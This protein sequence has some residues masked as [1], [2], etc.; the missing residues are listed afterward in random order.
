MNKF[1]CGCMVYCLR[2]ALT[3]VKQSN[4]LAYVHNLLLKM[5]IRC[6]DKTMHASEDINYVWWMYRKHT[7]EEYISSSIL[8]WH[9]L[10]PLRTWPNTLHDSRYWLNYHVPCLI[11]RRLHDHLNRLCTCAPSDWNIIFDISAHNI[12]IILH[13]YIYKLYII[14]YVLDHESLFGLYLT[15]NA[16]DVQIIFLLQSL[17]HCINSNECV[18]SARTSTVQNMYISTN[19]NRKRIITFVYTSTCTYTPE[20]MQ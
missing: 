13:A 11:Y 9:I 10:G 5:F 2:V 7:I 1:D 12:N 17:H 18:S 3:W 15:D 8:A 6:A 16:V 14:Y 20:R 19:C 4:Y